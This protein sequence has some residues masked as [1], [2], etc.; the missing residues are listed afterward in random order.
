MK[1][2]TPVTDQHYPLINPVKTSAI[3]TG[4]PEHLYRLGIKSCMYC[5]KLNSLDNTICVNCAEC[6]NTITIKND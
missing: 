2:E 5:G 4:K 1:I 3:Q 6:I